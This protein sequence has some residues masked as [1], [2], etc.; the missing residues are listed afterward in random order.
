LAD[1]LTA[2]AQSPP[3][4]SGVKAS[5]ISLP[6]GAGSIEG[7]GESF[8]PQ[9]N[10]GGSSYGVAIAVV[11]G[12]AG[13]T[14]SL[15]LAYDSYSGNGLAGIGWSLSLPSIKRQTDKGFPQYDSGDTFIYDGEEL[16][17]LNNA[18]SDWRCENERRFKRL[19]Q[20]DSDSDGLPDAWEVTDRDGTRHTFGRFRGQNGRWS[21]LEHPERGG[22]P[23]FDRTYC[24]MLDSTTDLHSNRVDYEYTLGTGVLY[25][26]RISYGHFSGNVHEVIFQ[27]E[28]RADAFDDYRPTFSARLEQRLKRIEV[29]SRGQLVRAYNLAYS[30]EPGDLTPDQVALQST[31]LDLGVTLLKRVVQLDRS[32]ADANFLPPLIFTYAGLDL[33]KADQRGFVTMPELD[34]AEPNGRVQLADLDGD[35]LPDL[36][37]TPIEGAGM[38][39]RVCL[40]R[41]EVIS[42]GIA[43]LMFAPSRL[44]Q[45]SS[46][47]DL[48]LPN[49]VVH[50]PKGKGLVDLSCL[51]QD[52]SNKRLDTFGN[53][54]RL[55]LVNED[56][57]GFSQDDVQSTVLQNPPAFVTYSD[58]GTRQM[59]VNF[60]KRGDFVNLE[61]TFGSMKVNTFFLAR[62]GTWTPRETMLPPSYPLANTFA[63]TNGE[64]NPCVHLADMNG[65]RMLDL[66]C[67]RVDNNGGG[68]RITV[69]YWPLCGLGRYGEERTLTNAPGDTFDIGNL[70]LRDVFVEDF[71]GDGL[72]DVLV[73]DGTGPEATLI[74]RVNIAGQRWS[75]P[76]VRTGLPRYAPR[77]PNNPTVLRLADLNANGSIDLLFRNT[78][79]ANT[80]RY[81]E[82]LPKGR[83]SILTGIDNSLGKRTTIVYGSAS[84]DEQ[85][86]RQAGHP[87]RTFAPFALE[88]VRQI[89]TTCG[90]DLNGDGREDTAVAE[91]RYRDAFYDGYEREFRGFAFAQRIDYGDDFLFDPVT[92]L[93]NVTTNWNRSRTP[94]GQLSGPSLVTRYRFH[95]GAA[96]QMD[97]DDYGADVPA[98]RL[99][100][101][102]TEVAGHEEE[103]LKGMQWVEEK[104]DPAVLHSAS[105][106]DFDAGCEAASLAASMESRARITPDAY[107]YT[108][109][110]QDWKV[111]RLYRPAEA[112]PYFADQDADGVLEDYR[113]T[114]SPP[115]PAGRFAALGIAVVPGNGRSV[116]F[117]FI[118]DQFTEVREANG[119]L[120]AALGFPAASLQRTTQIFDYD[121]YGNQIAL[122][123]FGLDAAG[124][125]DERFTTTTYALGGNALA[126]W[127]IDKPDTRTVS[128][129]NGAFVAKS[130][131]FYDGAPFVGVQGQIQNRALLSR[132]VD[133]IDATHTIDAVRARYDAFGNIE[134]SHDP[135]GNVHVVT[136]DPVFKTYPINETM[137]VGGGSADL[138]IS[139]AYDY[140]FG[141]A[142][143]S[144][145]FN[146][147]LTSYYYDSFARLVQVVR[148]GDSF[149]LPTSRFEYQPTDPVRARVYL[150]DAAGNLT[151]AAVPLGSLNRIIVRQREIAGQAGEYITV[152]YSDG[153]GRKI[154]ILEEGEAAGTWMV[155]EAT[156]FNLRGKIQSKWLAYQMGS[157]NMPDFPLLWPAGRPPVSD[158]VNPAVVATDFYYDPTGREIKTVAP[159]ETWG[160]PRR[161]AITQFL[162]MQKRI[163][164]Q[165]DAHSGSPHE[166]TP[167][168]QY[169]DGLSR[170]VAVEE[171]V[172]L[173]DAG[174]P[175]PPAIWRTEYTYDLNDQLT[176]V[177]DSQGNVKTMA[178]DG[179]RRLTSLDDPDRGKMSFTYDDASNLRE[180]VDGKGQHIV[181][182]Y[183]GVNRVKSEDYQ[184]GEPRTPDV[185]YFYDTPMAGLDLGDGTSGTAA[186]TK[187]QIAYVRDLSG[188]SHFSYDDRARIEWEVKRIPDR[189]NGE[190]VSFRTRFAYDSS[191]RLA[192][193]TYPD[194]DQLMCSYNSRNLL[195]RLSG[196]TL[197]DVVRSI[198]YTPSGQLRVIDYGNGVETRYGYDPRLRLTDLETTNSMSTRL[199]DLAYSFD[200]VGNITRIDDQRTWAGQPEA[201]NRFNTQ[202]F[203]YDDL[204][205]LT[206]T[207]YPRLG[208]AISSHVSYAYDR[209]GNMLS[210]TSDIDQK[211]SGL[212][213]ADLG[214]MA[215]GGSAG[216]ANRHGRNAGDAPGPHALSQITGTTGTRNY[217]Y[218]DN[219]NLTSGDG[220]TGQWDFKNRLVSA[221]NSQMLALY[222][223]DFRDRRVTKSVHW[224]S[225]SPEH[226][227]EPSPLNPAWRT[228]TTHYINRYYEVRDQDV[229]VKYVWN[230][231]TRIARITGLLGVATRLQ[232]VRLKEGWNHVC[233]TVGGQ[234]PALDPAQ[235]SDIGSCALF[236]DA[237]PGNGL[238]A[239]TAST[240][241]PAGAT[242]WI[243]ARRD[244]NLTLK[245]T[246]AAPLLPNLTGGSQFI[247]NAFGEPIDFRAIL[248]ASAWLAH[249]DSF[250]GRW[251]HQFP[252]MMAL[253]TLNEPA[254]WTAPGQ[255]IWTTGGTSGAIV[256]NVA[257]LEVRYYHQDH[258]GSTAVVT[259][260]NGALVEETSSYAFGQP[261]FDYR[262]APVWREPYGFIQK[263]RDAESGLDYFE[264]RYLNSTVGRFASV[265][266]LM[267]IDMKGRGQ[268]PQTLNVYAY[269]LNNP[270]KY[271]DPLGLEV[272][273]KTT[274]SDKGAETTTIKITGVLINESSTAM[275]DA[276]LKDV[277]AR[278]VGQVQSSFAGSEGDNKWSVSVDLRVVKDAK[279]I[280]SSDHVIR[281]VDVVDPDDATTL[282]EVNKIGGKEVKI[283]PGLISKK[284]SDP[285]N[286]S[287]E[288]TSAH[289]LGHALGLRH[290]TDPDNPIRDKMQNTALMR[291]TKDTDGT[292]VN[293]H[294][295]RRIQELYDGGKLNQ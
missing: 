203:T 198:Q 263:E 232:H 72:S 55:D 22:Q 90:Q 12:R 278:I 164:D 152:S 269:S 128:D 35:A 89:R 123:N 13:L 212:P 66:L 133:Y 118:S 108:R 222:T 4:K 130:V 250:S 167:I 283:K 56:R 160:G 146:G 7:L 111:R 252:G 124:Y 113:A 202:A 115:I 76:Y 171:V 99:I 273:V 87:W 24:W 85:R 131:Y 79:P 199:M 258:L 74:L 48:A 121:D 148:P 225:A 102:F 53:R 26:S 77:D 183:D 255:A 205:R 179:L 197:G 247:G 194:G 244:L 253:Q 181:Y 8:E 234:F 187:G 147:H 182:T 166:A 44:A 294:E 266:P 135:V 238:A 58:A 88:V 49:T 37:S 69:S 248:P 162:P 193:L 122:R 224:K 105:D 155:R 219:G 264:A 144:I 129:E 120:T 228:T 188:E 92:G 265:D 208:S 274:K 39:Q 11:P 159:P 29:R 59:D 168:V 38:A 149:A 82:L 163:F 233:L 289:E 14:P 176:Q 178:Y 112:L 67:L 281:I 70:D 137:V 104:V 101:E 97:N 275:T 231:Q 251:Q 57:L 235:N 254:Q 177:K 6:T 175:G 189:A 52:G 138:S 151:L 230:G 291:Q 63:G 54:S 207:D 96:D 107:V 141:V 204:Y 65:D 206:R 95:T 184:D 290:D 142:T 267:T 156:S 191:D 227:S 80:I 220:L 214:S 16:V 45:A 216:R 161:E 106:G 284:P 180:T 259:D 186:N 210:Q 47:V 241:V 71:T 279:D 150:Y 100:D 256:N 157:I 84:E 33:T 261:R 286:A 25:P 288:R 223:Y 172:K 153:C 268:I 173:T 114:P 292:D 262:P 169:V 109:F 295:I 213:V 280:K 185:E 242:L 165:E 117:P 93:M 276:E 20:I 21:V 277:K 136:W 145:D 18:G 132:R 34:L 143:N 68:Q 127:V 239:V 103:P 270:V 51:I 94:T 3:D 81:V 271:V 28:S 75:S 83:P 272:T 17:P 226:G 140:G 10:T 201:T 293:I 62:G 91:F 125:D 110:Y 200:G 19:R 243:Y 282:G 287:L 221:E 192:L 23:A 36:F 190:L 1:G 217:S 174:S 15:R 249:Y 236:S 195:Q 42:N 134:E 32:G 116:S 158:G 98:F 46:P 41:G 229:S 260:Q 285:G 196:A 211:E 86:A 126:L 215:S 73:L 40:N 257:G 245:G 43:R 50:D 246:P 240:P 2:R 209:I 237:A 61:P 9:L 78:S 154:A 27:Y 30:Y 218:D 31:Y 60:D 119:L 5:V 170:L 64:P 139:A